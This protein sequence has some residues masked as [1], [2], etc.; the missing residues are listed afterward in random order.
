M[1][2]T[3]HQ[4][5]DPA[6]VRR[7]VAALLPLSPEQQLEELGAWLAALHEAVEIAP[8]QRWSALQQLHAAAVQSL[9]WLGQAYLDALERGENG[10]RRPANLVQAYWRGVA[11][12]C[13]D[14]LHCIQDHRPGHEP[15]LSD[16][17]AIATLA[18]RALR[19]QIK[20]SAFLYS[21]LR[22]RVWAHMGAVLALAERAEIADQAVALAVSGQLTSV[23]LEYTRAMAFEAA[24]TDGLRPLEIELAERL[25]DH[26]A[27]DFGFGYV[28]EPETSHWVDLANGLPPVRFQKAPSQLVAGLRFFKLG[29]TGLALQSL[30]DQVTLDG[31]L[32]AGVNLGRAWSLRLLKRVLRHLALHFSAQLPRRRHVRFPLKGQLRVASGLAA[33][34]LIFA[35]PANAWPDSVPSETWEIENASQGGCAA[36]VRGPL[37]A[38]PWLSIG[39][40]LVSQPGEGG[41][42]LLGIVRRLRREP[43]GRFRVGVETL[44]RDVHCLLLVPLHRPGQIA[45]SKLSGLLLPDVVDATQTVRLL[46]PKGSFALREVL[47]YVDP[48]GRLCRLQPEALLDSGDD[49]E[50]TRYR[51]LG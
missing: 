42:N 16:F 29:K 14:C 30:L 19:I 22:E 51:R 32:P 17:A 49:Y 10:V 27:G 15:L 28:A 4:L 48:Q 3:Q 7:I 35:M 20:W 34:Q 21:P 23:R 6:S 9:E 31:A 46:L 39:A 47:A 13:E 8:S 26:F 33:A 18:I 37:D 12:V 50:W 40:L 36:H 2:A 43:D 24:D 45:G 5:G 41:P 11:A 44:G 25:V 38:S 1:S